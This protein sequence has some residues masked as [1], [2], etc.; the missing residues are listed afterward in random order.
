V[1]STSMKVANMTAMATIQGLTC[2][3]VTWTTA[4]TPSARP[5][6][7]AAGDARDPGRHR[8]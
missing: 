5:T 1:S 6:S 7:P 2:L 3:S 4:C 8:G